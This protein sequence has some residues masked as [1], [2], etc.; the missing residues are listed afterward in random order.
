MRRFAV[1]FVLIFALSVTASPPALRDIAPPDEGQDAGYYWWDSNESSGW[2][3][4]SDW[5][6]PSNSMP[7]QG[8]DTVGQCLCLG[9]IA[10]ESA[11]A[12]ELGDRSLGPSPS[13]PISGKSPSDQALSFCVCADHAA[14]ALDAPLRL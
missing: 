5:R 14:L 12:R 9:G 6:N 8:D 10:Q 1:V 4:D 13:P 11:A 7:W 2:A 3:P